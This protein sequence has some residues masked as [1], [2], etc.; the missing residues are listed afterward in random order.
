MSAGGT[1]LQT[2]LAGFL[3]AYRESR[4]LHPRQRQVCAHIGTCRTPA[5]GGQR[6][7]CESERCDYERVRY[8]ACRDRHCP[9][10]QGRASAKWCERQ[11]AR[12]LPVT[13]YHLVFTLPDD[14]NPW[15]QAAP[16]LIYH[17]LF[18]SA[19][20]TLKAFARNP[21]HLNGEAGM[22]AVLHTWG[23]TL[24]QHVH[25]H[26]LVPGGALST[27][28]RWCAAKGHYLFPSRAVSRRFRGHFVSAL[29]RGAQAGA[30][31]RVG[32]RADIDAMLDTL[33]AKDW[34][35][36]AKPCIG[37]TERVV[38]YLGRYTHRI[39][40]SDRRL[41]GINGTRVG[42]RYRDYRDGGREKTTWLEG[43]ELVR[44]FL[45]HVL[46][47]GL[48][49]IRHYGFLANRCWAA[50][51]RHIRRALE[52]AE[53]DVPNS[54]ARTPT[55]DAEPCPRC[56]RAPLPVVALLAPQRLAPG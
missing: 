49:R 14:L 4:S 43:T 38:S 36:Y 3:P 37:H 29:R 27:Q 41:I 12:V 32:A 25:L 24:S 52:M 8:H 31:A 55:P 19:W 50:R 22:T 13:Y 16:A 9:K 56:R 33:M 1:D 51:A 5:L 48:M 6:L 10:C 42:L 35:V 39:A 7:R 30:L 45:L 15:V 21:T 17:Q 44:R 23:Q 54:D 26:C 28:G 18:Q 2:V 20:S 11:L 46:P 53:E 40:L 34:V 47:K